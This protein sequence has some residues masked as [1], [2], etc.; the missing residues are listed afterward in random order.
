MPPPADPWEGSF[1]A[2]LRNPLWGSQSWLQP[3]FRRPG[4]RC[5][6]PECER[7]NPVTHDSIRRRPWRGL[8]PSPDRDFATVAIPCSTHARPLPTCWSLL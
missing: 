3:P 6:S 2:H 1:L 7:P 4:S 8:T 5:S